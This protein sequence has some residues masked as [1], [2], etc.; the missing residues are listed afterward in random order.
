MKQ[1]KFG[2]CAEL[3]LQQNDIL[4][5]THKNPDGDTVGSAGALC[6]ALR[7]A[8]KRAYVYPNP[9]IGGHLRPYV[10][11]FLAPENSE[12]YFAYYVAVDVA[13][14][15]L[16]P[17]GFEGP[18]DLCIDHHEINSHYAKRELIKAERSA[19]GEIILRIIKAMELTPNAQEATLL[20]IAVSTD[21]GCFQYMNTD[22]MTFE[23]AA[24]L[25]HLGADSAGVN[26]AF[27][28]KVSPER[29]KLEG[30]IYST[31]SFHRDGKVTIAVITLE[32]LAR[33]GAKEEDCDDLAGLA[34]RAAG[35]LVSVTIREKAEGECR[36]SV[37][38]GPEVS[39]A[40][41]CAVFGGGGHAMAAGC[42]ISATPEKAKTMLLAVI[43]EIMQ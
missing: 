19:C 33:T 34:G 13:S 3:L 17:K 20:Y 35:S 2:K 23:T 7:R 32:M 39:S 6:S 18:V 1:M 38:S 9:Q 29:L 8:G 11:E 21:T 24:E 43:D 28:R 22:A 25:L 42:T 36:I 41:I 4:I 26:T 16:F 30:E 31:L 14:E 5:L 40:D 37:R 12:E 15:K 27:F 10:E